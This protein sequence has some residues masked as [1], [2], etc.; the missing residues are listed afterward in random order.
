MDSGRPALRPAMTTLQLEE[1]GMRMAALGSL[2]LCVL[3][4]PARADDAAD[5]RAII[6]K[7][8]KAGGGEEKLAKFKSQTFSETGKYYGTGAALDYTGEYAVQLPDRFRMEIKGVFTMVVA[9]DKGWLKDPNGT[10]EMSKEQLDN[11][12]RNLRG[13]E[14]ASLLPLKDKAFTITLQ[15]EAKVDDKAVAVVKVTRKEWPEVVLSFDKSSGLLVKTE[16]MVKSMED[17][18]GKELKQEAYYKD[19]KDVEGCKMPTKI[20]IKRDGKDFVEA[21]LSDIKPAEK[22]DPKL[23]EKP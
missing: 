3:V 13:G 10:V 18:K 19:F 16:Q 4:G 11:E 12:R 1:V 21:T 14:I 9:G 7:A 15:P 22:L 8:I 2:I 23:F 6:N 5:A 20:V 17:L